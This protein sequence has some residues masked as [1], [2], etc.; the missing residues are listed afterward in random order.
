MTS[1]TSLKISNNYND[2]NGYFT[3]GLTNTLPT[4]LGKLKNL[5]HIDLSNNYLT[6][7]LITEFGVLHQLQTLNLQ[8]NF[9]QGPIPDE[10]ANCVSMRE[11]LLQDNNVDGEKFGVPEEICRLPEL[12]LA[13]VDCELEHSCSCCL[14][15]C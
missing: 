7:T 12:D 15:T 9:L 6:G 11:I 14:T 2:D 3:W 5:Q 1:L 4:E 13:R 10:Y 8:N